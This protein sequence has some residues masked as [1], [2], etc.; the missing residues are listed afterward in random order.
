VDWSC[1]GQKLASGSYDKTVSVFS[2]DK[3]RLVIVC[4]CVS[5]YRYYSMHICGV[6]YGTI[7]LSYARKD[8][9]LFVCVYK[10]YDDS[11][12]IEYIDIAE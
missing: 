10:G 2:L 8:I 12:L 9:R 5:V 11:R 4:V 3:D 1:D 6:M 7:Q